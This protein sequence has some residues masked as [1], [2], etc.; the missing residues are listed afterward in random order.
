MR[1]KRIMNAKRLVTTLTSCCLAVAISGIA[2]GAA[3]AP[4]APH[5]AATAKDAAPADTM[6]ACKAM[7]VDHEAMMADVK[8]GDV[9]LDAL[10]ASMNAASG[11]EKA[12]ATAVVVT[13]LAAQRKARH[14]GMMTMQSGMMSHMMAH[15]QGGKGSMAT[16]PMMKS[17]GAA[18][19]H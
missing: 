13:E 6:A 10:V 16:C 15:M 8:A 14:A 18:M 1:E 7:M 19:K 17:M 2:E 9:R 12:T 11:A 5:H 4:A 3:Q